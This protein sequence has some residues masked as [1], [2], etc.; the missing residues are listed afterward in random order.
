MWVW[1]SWNLD[2]HHILVADQVFARRIA[3]N[4]MELDVDLIWEDFGLK[5]S[6]R[7]IEL[8]LEVVDVTPVHKT[9][10]LP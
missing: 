10:L 4:F 2:L 5:P 8:D 9:R 6:E 7:V 3:A 1:W